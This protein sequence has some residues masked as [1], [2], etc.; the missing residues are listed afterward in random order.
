MTV[1]SPLPLYDVP[2]ARK[3]IL[4]RPPWDEAVEQP[5]VRRA[6]AAVFG[7]DVSPWE[8]VRRIVQ[9]VRR[10][11]DE[12]LRHWTERLDR[13]PVAS[14]RVPQ[15][16]LQEALNT[17]DPALRRVLE[18]AADRI[19][20]FHQAQP[21]HA[22]LTQALGGSLGHLLRPLERVGVYVPGGSAPLPST[23]LMTVI[24]AKV[25]GVERVI[26]VTPPNRGY[27]DRE[28]PVDPALLAAAALAGADEVYTVGGAQAIAALAYGTESIPKVDKIV[29]PG[30]IFVTMAKKLV[31]GDVGIDGLAGPTE[32][33]IVA[34]GSANPEWVAADLLAQAEHDPLAAAILLSPDLAFIQRVQQAVAQQ[35][36][37]RARAEVI[38]LSLQHRGGA[39]H[40]R[41]LEEALD[42][43]NAY[44]PEHL[45]LAVADPWRWLPKVRHAGCVFLGEHS[46]EVLGDYLAGPNHVLPTGGSARYA[47]GLHVGSFMRWIGLVALDP[48]TARDLAPLAAA[49]AQA[50]TLEAHAAA[51]EAR[52]ER[53][54]QSAVG[55][56]R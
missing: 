28:V 23:V 9:D 44:A 19:R 48:E 11:G 34:D 8:A 39:V 4:R 42:L 26:V 20:A 46:F 38:R 10:R 40:T 1:E 2:T 18:A 51:A 52:M 31:Y 32:T 17:L 55:S 6:V 43:A 30:N 27:A 5:A 3:T 12:A 37:R 49:F 33:L 14:F 50:E 36:P 41:D 25:A 24:P 54:G 35:L 29:G 47:S 7:P 53:S 56:P 21:L 15:A 13:V 16:A 22:W 45:A